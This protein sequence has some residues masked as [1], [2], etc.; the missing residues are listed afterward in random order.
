MFWGNEIQ[1][2]DIG[3]GVTTMTSLYGVTEFEFFE[4][5]EHGWGYGGEGEREKE[6]EGE[7]ALEKWMLRNR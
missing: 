5:R 2:K 7:K 6:K 1:R 4:E 3:E